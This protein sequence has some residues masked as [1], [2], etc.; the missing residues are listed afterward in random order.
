MISDSFEELKNTR[1]KNRNRLMIAQIN[2]NSLR[3]KFELP[4]RM[5]HHDLDTLLICETKIACSFPTAQCQMEGFTTYRLDRNAN[6]GGI[7][8]YIRTDIPSILLNSDIL[9]ES[10]HIETTIRK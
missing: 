4:V 5:M 1:L 9:I 10:C 2:I 3:N 7:L 8:L 6:G